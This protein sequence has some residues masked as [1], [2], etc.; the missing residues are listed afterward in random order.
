MFPLFSPR[1]QLLT[2]SAFIPDRSANQANIPN[3]GR[4]PGC[5]RY[6]H[7]AALASL[8]GSLHPWVLGATNNPKMFHPTRKNPA[9][10]CSICFPST[11]P[12]W[13]SPPQSVSHT[14]PVVK[15]P[16]NV[17]VCLGSRP[18]DHGP[19]SSPMG[20]PRSASARRITRRSKEEGGCRVA[21]AER[22]GTLVPPRISHE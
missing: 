17:N 1:K 5:G 8:K 18:P 19:P 2:I 12:I 9:S 3:K 16:Q 20:T 13:D 6:Q 4:G 14:I 10:E 22:G 7:A 11:W 15:K 21:R